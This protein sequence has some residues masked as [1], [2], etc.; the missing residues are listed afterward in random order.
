MQVKEPA[1]KRLALFARKLPWGSAG[2]STG[3]YIRYMLSTVMTCCGV[4][5]CSQ[6]RS[7]VKLDNPALGLFWW[8][9]VLHLNP[10]LFLC[11]VK[12]MR[13]I[14]ALWFPI[15]D[16]LLRYRFKIEV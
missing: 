9:I 16:P 5:V 10:R 14:F 2:F 11:V 4:R 7:P 15:D 12:G 13:L 1:P 3:H 6:D 8:L